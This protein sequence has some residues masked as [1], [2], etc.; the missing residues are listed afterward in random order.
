MHFEENTIQRYSEVDLLSTQG[1]IGRKRYFLASVIIPFVIFWSI[2][3][4]AGAL[5]HLGSLASFVSYAILGLAVSAMSLI[6]VR[7]T[8]Q[9]CHDFNKSGWLSIFA[10]I[11]F[12]NFIFALIPGN[13]GLNQYGEA[14][15]PA[16]GFIKVAFYGLVLLILT[17]AVVVAAQLLNSNI[18]DWFQL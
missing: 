8:I 7:L 14:P 1:R 16:S 11:P 13:N 3:S 17:S 12:T 10:L 4:I 15:E 6:L 18:N 9:R 2:A 5:T